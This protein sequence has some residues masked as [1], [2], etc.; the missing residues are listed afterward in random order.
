[1]TTDTTSSTGSTVRGSKDYYTAL[2]QAALTITSSLELDQVLQ[3]VVKS[4][5]EAMEVKACGLRL[6]DHDT[7]QLQLAAVYGLSSDYLS[8]GSVNVSSSPIDMEA[9][10]GKT[11]C[12]E[13][14]GTDSRFQYPAAARQEWIVSV[15]CVPL[16]VRGNAIGVMRVYTSKPTVFEESD[17]QFLSVLASLAALAIDN[18]RLYESLKSSFNGVMDAFWGMNISL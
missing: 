9:M 17:I 5:T 1:M 3:S 15:L 13:D 8:K 14:V 11:V 2:Y 16:E 4:T 7:G 6:F 18:A 10:S 12:I